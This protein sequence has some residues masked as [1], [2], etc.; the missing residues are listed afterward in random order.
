MVKVTTSKLFICFSNMLETLLNENHQ[1]IFFQKFNS[2]LILWA[3][4]VTQSN[5]QI[6]KCVLKAN[7]ETI[8]SEKTLS[9]RSYYTF[10]WKYS[11]RNATK[12]LSS[13][14]VVKASLKAISQKHRKSGKNTNFQDF[15]LIM[16]SPPHRFSECNCK[17]SGLSLRTILHLYLAT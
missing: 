17:Y 16:P 3:C 7:V 4:K 15:Y 14:V 9:A 10:T 5:N 6:W 8:F 1:E 13:H 2:V 12:K 11:K